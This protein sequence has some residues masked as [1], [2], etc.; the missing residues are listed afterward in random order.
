MEVQS[1]LF[2]SGGILQFKNATLIGNLQIE[3][4][5]KVQATGLISGNVFVTGW[6]SRLSVGYV[7]EEETLTIDGN[8]VL[9]GEVRY[10]KPP[11]QPQP[12][13]AFV[14]GDQPHNVDCKW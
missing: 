13:L 8:L 3:N 9:S 2:V 11:D 10:N 7:N 5:G 6:P 14:A 12:K 4:N 1:T